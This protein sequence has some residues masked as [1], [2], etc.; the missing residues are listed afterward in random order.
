MPPMTD[1]A[2][3]VILAQPLIV[4]SENDVCLVITRIRQ[5]LKQFDLNF[6]AVNR[7]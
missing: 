3:R 6:S 7:H 2:D 4:R 5:T 1:Y